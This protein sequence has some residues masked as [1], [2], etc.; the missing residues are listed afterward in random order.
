MK[1]NKI[2]ILAG[3]ICLTSLSSCQS[4]KEGLSGQKKK[5]GDEFLVKKKTL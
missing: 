5:S 4:V 2:L 1:I 3:L